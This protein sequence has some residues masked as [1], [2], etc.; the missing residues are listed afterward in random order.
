MTT[1]PIVPRRIVVGV[2]GSPESKEALRWAARLADAEKATIEVVSA[3]EDPVTYG[4]AA[5]PT[6]PESNPR[7]ELE[8]ATEQDVDEVFGE[9]RP[10]GLEIKVAEGTP[11][12]VL[13][14]A[15]KDAVAIVV[16]SRGRGGFKELLLGSVSHAVTQHATVPVLVVHGHDSA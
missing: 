16:G 15:A 7:A 6:Y 9:Q 2:D 11:V 12:R 4:W 10:A 14:R 5:Y 8:K 1:T 3:W 13:L